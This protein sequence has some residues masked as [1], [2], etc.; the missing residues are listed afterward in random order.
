[1]L[2]VKEPYIQLHLAIFFDLGNVA[3]NLEIQFD[4]IDTVFFYN[5]KVMGNVSYRILKICIDTTSFNNSLI[6]N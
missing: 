1:M 5:I 3:T 6:Q 4:P 2:K